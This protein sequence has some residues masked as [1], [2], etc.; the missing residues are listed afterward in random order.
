MTDPQPEPKPTMTTTSVKNDIDVS[1]FG[2]SSGLADMTLILED[3]RI[4]VIKALLVVTS[5]VFRTLLD[6][7]RKENDQNR[8]ELTL[9]GKTFDTFIPFLRCIYP[10][11]MDRVTDANATSILPLAWEYQIVKLME[12][13]EYCILAL[14]GDKTI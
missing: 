12:K 13:C 6:S 11:L 2:E 3:I 4:P 14:I 8:N 10:D 5:P 9:Q 7:E 1:M